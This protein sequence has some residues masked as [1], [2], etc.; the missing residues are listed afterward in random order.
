MFKE[1]SVYEGVAA[2]GS[3]EQDVAVGVVQETEQV[4]RNVVL[5]CQEPQHC[6]PAVAMSAPA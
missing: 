2:A 3:A 4:V 5:P 1:Q 6:A